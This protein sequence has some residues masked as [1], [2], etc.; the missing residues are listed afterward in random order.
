[1]ISSRL[2]INK[3]QA[4]ACKQTSNIY[5][6]VCFEFSELMLINVIANTYLSVEQL[7]GY[8]VSSSILGQSAHRLQ[9]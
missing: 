8:R 6:F 3:G 1:M 2:D 7:P 9:P 5:L 4:L